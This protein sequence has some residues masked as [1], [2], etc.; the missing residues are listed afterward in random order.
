MRAEA[1]IPYEV[2]EV[3]P[4]HL[5]SRIGKEIVMKKEIM[6]LN[7]HTLITGVGI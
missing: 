6:G 7:T 2:W 1:S 4:Y 5:I 3:N